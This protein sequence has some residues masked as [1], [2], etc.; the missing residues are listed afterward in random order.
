VIKQV[1][2]ENSLLSE[3]DQFVQKKENLYTEK[4]NLFTEKKKL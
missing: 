1:V 4:E 3:L 2:G